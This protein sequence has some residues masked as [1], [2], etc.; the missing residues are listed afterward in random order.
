M[1]LDIIKQWHEA[2]AALEA[3]KQR[4][5]ELRHIIHATLFDSCITG[6]HKV[7]L[8][9]GFVLKCI[10]KTN[11]TVDEG[12]INEVYNRLKTSFAEGEYVFQDLFKWKPTLST[13]SYNKLSG[14]M[15]AIVDM[16]ITSKPG[17]PTIELVEPKVVK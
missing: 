16:A 8:G 7:E 2:Q 13:G 15:K 17:T 4:E 9:H 6:T 3:A 1:N 12:K 5:K 10:G 14:E 11:Y